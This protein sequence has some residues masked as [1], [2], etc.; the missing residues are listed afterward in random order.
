MTVAEFFNTGPQVD[1]LHDA[2][3]H[4]V[5][6][7]ADSH[8]RSAQKRL[9]PSEVG[10]P[11]ARKMV[12]ALLFGSGNTATGKPINPPGDPLPAYVGT[13]GHKQ[14]EAAVHLDN[15]LREAEGKEPRWLSERKVTVREDLSGTCDLYDMQTGTVI[16]LKFPGVTAFNEY[17]RYGPSSTYRV[18][19]HLYGAGYR[20]EG[21]NVHSVG[22]WFLPRGGQLASAHLWTEPYDQDVVDETL[23]RIDYAHNIIGMLELEHHPERLQFVPTTP[24]ACMWCPYFSPVANTD[25]SACS[26]GETWR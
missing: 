16:D 3:K 14:F 8:P 23:M 13:A 17:K 20:N 4:V 19:A 22:I 6:Q 24:Q 1:P 9:G 18:Q 7:H 25:P 12:Q 26:G 15:M 2:L 21:F 10:H 5:R 11:C